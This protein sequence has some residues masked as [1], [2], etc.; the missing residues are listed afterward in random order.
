MRVCKIALARHV[1]PPKA[2]RPGDLQWYV[3]TLWLSVL[4]TRSK[5]WLAARV[6]FWLARMPH[7]APHPA[8][9]EQ[10]EALTSPAWHACGCASPFRPQA[11]HAIREKTR[12]VGIGKSVSRFIC[13]FFWEDV[14]P[15][16]TS[17]KVVTSPDL[18]SSYQESQQWSLCYVLSCNLIVEFN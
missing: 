8:R 17:P 12:D 5:S 13:Y 18:G 1:W 16:T 9:A 2:L 4:C 15:M 11:V 6:S 3:F 10:G 7:P 14:I